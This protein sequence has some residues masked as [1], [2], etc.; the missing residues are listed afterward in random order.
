M[1]QYNDYN[2]E[3]SFKHQSSLIL[4]KRLIADGAPIS[5]VGIQG[6]WSLTTNIDNIEKSILDY[7]A[8]GLKVAITELDVTVTGGNSGQFPGAG[9]AGGAGGGRGGF[10]R[11]GAGG[12]PG[13][14]PGAGGAAPGAAAGGGAAPPPVA[15]TSPARTPFERQADFYARLFEM[16]NRHADV[17]DRV[18]FW[19]INDP[20][21][22]KSGQQP[23]LFDGDMKPKPAFQSIIDVMTKPKSVVMAP[24]LGF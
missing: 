2:I 7:K 15:A 13:G 11:G 24:G 17:I 6:H 5:A 22:W 16:L 21:S 14:A 20:R 19:G 12:A 10:G 8:L 1:L 18:T 4:L 3:S 23:L 9:G